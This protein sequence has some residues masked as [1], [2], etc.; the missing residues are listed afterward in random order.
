M[1]MDST[2]L[3]L[4]GGFLKLLVFEDKHSSA[5]HI[6]FSLNKQELHIADMK[7]NRWNATYIATYSVKVL[8]GVTQSGA[9]EERVYG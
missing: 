1:D 4:D 9:V 3:Q 8:V 5:A 7:R 2:C 6:T